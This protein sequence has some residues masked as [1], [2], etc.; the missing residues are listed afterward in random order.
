[1]VAGYP[2]NGPFVARAARIRDELRAQGPNIYDRG[3]VTREVYSLYTRVEPGNSGGP[4]LS[5]AGD[6]YGIIFAK[7]QDDP[8]T[9]YAVT[10]DEA[11]ADARAG[12][13]STAAVSTGACA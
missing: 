11:S 4:L 10:A 13:S 3:R 2:N 8:N 7:S 9:G 6:V 1:V 12:G 5:P